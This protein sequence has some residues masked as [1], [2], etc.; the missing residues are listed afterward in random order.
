MDSEFLILKAYG[1]YRLLFTP[2][3][4]GPADSV[5]TE[6]TNFQL[7]RSQRIYGDSRDEYYYFIHQLTCKI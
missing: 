4:T 7:E 3:P 6:R 1:A 2:P 5:E